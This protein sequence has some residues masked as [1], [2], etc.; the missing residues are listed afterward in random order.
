MKRSLPGGDFEGD[1]EMNMPGTNAHSGHP[2][3]QTNGGGLSNAG[4]TVPHNTGN[5]AITIENTPLNIDGLIIQ[6]LL[7]DLEAYRY[8]YQFCRSQLENDNVHSISP[9]EQRTFQ[10]RLLDL[11]HQMRMLNH[12]VQLM[13][14]S[15]TNQ[16]HVAGLVGRAGATTANAYYGAYPPGT[17]VQPNAYATGA[18]LLAAGGGGGGFVMGSNMGQYQTI[19]PNGAAYAGHPEPPQERRGPGRPAGSKNRPRASMD[20]SQPP[21]VPPTGS[22]KAAA[23]ASAGAKRDLPTE[24][25]VATR[26]L[27]CLL[28]L[29]WHFRFVLLTGLAPALTP[30]IFEIF[31]YC[32]SPFTVST[33]TLAVLP[34]VDETLSVEKYKF[35][36]L[37]R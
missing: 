21:A 19:Q 7:E 6:Q 36:T 32:D 35:Y 11:G 1:V 8:D 26:K 15:M 33:S 22:A 23:L 14:A 17:S 27:F 37:S 16:R 12:R 34:F 5:S 30:W 28:I 18:S 4:T 31:I 10:L 20:P 29:S 25:R 3:A 2:S 24:I 9:A 13:Q